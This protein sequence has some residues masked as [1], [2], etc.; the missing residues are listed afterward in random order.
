LALFLGVCKDRI[1]RKGGYGM[2]DRYAELMGKI[3]AAKNGYTA[4]EKNLAE[5]GR[6]FSCRLDDKLRESLVKRGKSSLFI[7]TTASIALKI[8]TS[9]VTSYFSRADLAVISADDPDDAYAREAAEAIQESLRYY[10]RHKILNLFP[11]LSKEILNCCVYL[12]CALKVYW[13][14]NAPRV[15][16]IKLKDLWFDPTACSAADAEYIIHRLFIKPSRLEALFGLKA[17][18]IKGNEPN[19]EIFDIYEKERGVWKLSTLIGE[20]L[21]RDGE[22]LKDSLPIFFGTLL[23]QLILPNEEDCVEIYGSSPIEYILPLQAE[24]NQLRNQQLDAVRLQLEPRY[25]FNKTA[26]INP[27]TFYNQR[28]H[29]VNDVSGVKELKAPDAAFSQVQVGQIQLEFQEVSAVTPYNTGTNAHIGNMTAT[30]T[31]ILTSEANQR[32]A[33]YTHSL[34][35]TLIEPAVFHLATLIW[36]YG[37]TRFLKKINRSRTPE[38]FVHV[39]TGL[40]DNRGAIENAISPL[41]EREDVG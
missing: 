32:L 34:N 38:L 37:D 20:R 21:V 10:T 30:G 36:K 40:S 9:I 6:A 7:P 29:A 4:V 1:I 16:G 35:E 39:D 25:L 18:D 2:A 31:A 13:L 15:D 12:G 28:L 41:K 33:V 3:E 26:G 8:Y 23:P 19:A 14:G 22:V 24:I 17:Q 27:L 5:L 11:V